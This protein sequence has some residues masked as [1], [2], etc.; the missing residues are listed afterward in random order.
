MLAMAMLLL[1]MLCWAQHPS[2]RKLIR[3][4][5]P[6]YPSLLKDKKIGGIVNVL[7]TVSADG[8]VKQTQI[9]GGN[10]VLGTA[11]ETAIHHWK[12]VPA[13][14]ETTESVTIRFNPE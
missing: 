7:V 13:A 11:A 9:V 14:N 6:E 10:P 1:P 5:D 4:T 8:T 2:G 12:Y 3:R